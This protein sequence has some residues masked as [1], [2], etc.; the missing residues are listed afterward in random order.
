MKIVHSDTHALTRD[1]ILDCVYHVIAAD[2]LMNVIQKL[3]FALYVY[4]IVGKFR[5]FIFKYFRTVGT[6]RLEISA[7]SVYKGMKVMLLEERHMIVDQLVQ[8]HL[9]AYVIDRDQLARHAM[10]DD[11]LARYCKNLTVLENIRV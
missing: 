3:V 8:D 2:I 11:A 4:K 9:N 5:V 6:K 1:C 10:V 7:I